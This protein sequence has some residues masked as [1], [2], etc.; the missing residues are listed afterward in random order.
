[1]SRG[2]ASALPTTVYEC[3]ISACPWTHT[4]PPAPADIT[5]WPGYGTMPLAEL[6]A[7]I[8]RHRM[9]ENEAAVLAHLEEHTAVQWAKELAAV[10]TELA[11]ARSRTRFGAFEVVAR[12]EAPEG[13]ITLMPAPVAPQDQ[14]P[15]EPGS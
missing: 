7:H 2:L 15:E 4:E 10:R 1:M 5:T 11:A 9:K 3:P 14:D 12:D 8:S 13:S 6:P